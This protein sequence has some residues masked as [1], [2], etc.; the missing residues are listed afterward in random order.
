MKHYR[1]SIPKVAREHVI[2]VHISGGKYIAEYVYKGEIVGRRYFHEKG[3]LSYEYPIRNGLKHGM[4]Y[5][6]DEPGKILSAEPYFKGLAHGIAK[7]WSDDGKLIG[8]YTMKWGTGIDL[9]WNEYKDKKPHLSEVL[10]LKD[11]KPHGFNW[12]LNSNATIYWERHFFE[13]KMHGVEREWNNKGR[14][15][16]GYPKYWVN[17]IKVSKRQYI[18]DFAK[19][20]EL[21]LFCEK[22]NLPKR[23]FS[24]EIR[25]HLNVKK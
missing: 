5:R 17:D 19:D 8:T 20:R 4:H 13:G 25:K 7:Q 18:K 16:R 2:A 9:W 6:S 3:E 24:P 11:G 23:K 15:R 10:Y 21:P 1:S 22:D 12:W 14:L